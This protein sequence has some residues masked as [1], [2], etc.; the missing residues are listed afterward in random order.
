MWRAKGMARDLLFRPCKSQRILNT[1]SN[2]RVQLCRRMGTLLGDW[3]ASRGQ[4]TVSYRC[5]PVCLHLLRHCDLHSQSGLRDLALAVSQT[6]LRLR[7][8]QYTVGSW[9]KECLSCHLIHST[10][11]HIHTLSY[12]ETYACRHAES[13]VCVCV[14]VQV[15]VGR[16]QRLMFDF[17]LSHSLNLVCTSWLDWLA[18][19]ASSIIQSPVSTSLV[20]GPQCTAAPIFFHAA[21]VLNSGP[22]VCLTDTFLTGPSPQLYNKPFLKW[23]F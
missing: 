21:L 4:R 15:C 17:L 19:W 2:S 7:M 6:S 14:L 5:M 12:T 13:S 18:L 3:E 23:C 9:Q 22:H 10:H 16:V 1:H 8:P 11:W 20:P